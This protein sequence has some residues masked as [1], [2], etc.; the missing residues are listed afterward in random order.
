MKKGTIGQYA[1]YQKAVAEAAKA[2][3][4]ETWFSLET[5]TVVRRLLEH[6]RRSGKL[7]R[8]FYG[9]VRTGEDWLEENDVVGKGWPL[10]WHIQDTDPSSRR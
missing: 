2:N 5:P 4:K 7:I 1:D 6:Y 8:I 9:D 3:I 10:V